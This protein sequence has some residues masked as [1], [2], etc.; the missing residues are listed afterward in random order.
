MHALERH[1][2]FAHGGSAAF[3]GA[4]AHVASG[5][6]AGAARLQRAGRASTVF[7]RG[8]TDYCVA[9]ANEALFIALDLGRQP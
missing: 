9:G 1:A 2:A 5:E 3:H 6:D 8:R 7:P 4:G